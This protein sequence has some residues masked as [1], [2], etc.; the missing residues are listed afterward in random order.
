MGRCWLQRVGAA[1]GS[2]GCASACVQAGERS[3]CVPQRQWRIVHD[4]RVSK[5]GRVQS[6][7]DTCTRTHARIQLG[8]ATLPPPQAGVRADA[9]RGPRGVYHCQLGPHPA[10]PWLLESHGGH[11]CPPRRAAGGQPAAPARVPQVGALEV[12]LGAVC[13]WAR[14]PSQARCWRPAAAPARVPSVCVK[15]ALDS[16]HCP[17]RCPAPTACA[18]V[19]A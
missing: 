8:P 1:D 9:V 16:L 11:P 4:A 19:A 14:P 17:T 13:C 7:T 2:S 18:L 12:L 5:A 10:G 3:C 15:A 6:R